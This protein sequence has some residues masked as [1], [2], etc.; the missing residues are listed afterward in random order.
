MRLQMLLAWVCVDAGMTEVGTLEAG[1]VPVE[2]ACCP[3]VW[4]SFSCVVD[5]PVFATWESI[6][7]QALSPRNLRNAPASNP[8]MAIDC[9]E[10][11]SA[12]CS[13]QVLW[14]SAAARTAS[15]AS[16]IRLAA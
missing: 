14:R 5:N 4:R 6:M 7:L 9:L 12:N 11:M 2:I 8:P 10:A 15:S 16:E 13:R 3:A 1:R